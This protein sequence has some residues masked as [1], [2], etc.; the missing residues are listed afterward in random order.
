MHHMVPVVLCQVGGPER[1]GG[2][3]E[4]KKMMTIHDHH[5]DQNIR[6]YQDLQGCL[7]H[8]DQVILMTTTTLVPPDAQNR[9]G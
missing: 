3:L 2:L 4:L 5:V 9:L 6:G 1:H 7:N 8:Q